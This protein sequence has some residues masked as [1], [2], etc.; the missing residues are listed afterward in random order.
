MTESA[1]VNAMKELGISREDAI[2]MIAADEA[3]ERGEEMDFDLPAEKQKVVKEMTKVGTRKTGEK[4]ERKR[5]PNEDKRAIMQELFD[6]FS[7]M[8]GCTLSN[9]ERQVDFTFNGV[10]YSVTLTA[11][12]PPKAK[13]QDG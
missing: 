12:R 3:I 8:P 4:V 6:H 13:T 10:Q 5:K 1:I 9:I 7:G 11:H 2:E